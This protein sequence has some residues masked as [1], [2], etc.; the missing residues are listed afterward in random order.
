MRAVGDCASVDQACVAPS[1]TLPN[2]AIVFGSVTERFAAV[3]AARAARKTPPHGRTPRSHRTLAAGI[4]QRRPADALGD[5]WPRREVPA[6]FDAWERAAYLLPSLVGNGQPES[7]SPSCVRARR[8]PSASTRWSLLAR[9]TPTRR[10]A[11]LAALTSRR[12]SL[13][14]LP[15]GD[16]LPRSIPSRHASSALCPPPSTPA[17]RTSPRDGSARRCAGRRQAAAY[18]FSRR[19]MRWA[20]RPSPIAR[21][22]ALGRAVLRACPE[23]C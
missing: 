14:G 7:V 10:G 17:R 16:R 1:T 4:P 21:L 8:H 12:A 13:R 19:V 2:R 15:G 23:L 5:V 11:P 18:C 9:M 22:A 20:R 6:A 3:L